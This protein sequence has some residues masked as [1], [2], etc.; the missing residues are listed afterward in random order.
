MVNARW[1]NILID[2]KIH[3][4]CMEM[5]VVW[6]VVYWNYAIYILVKFVIF[7]KIV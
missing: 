5:C 1:D 2:N 4:F 6:C 7:V 3:V